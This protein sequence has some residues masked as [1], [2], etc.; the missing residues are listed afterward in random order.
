MRQIDKVTVKGSIEPIGLF[1]I[2]M[3]VDNLPP[4]TDPKEKYPDFSKDDCK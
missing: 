2:D 1:T 4:S 3:Y